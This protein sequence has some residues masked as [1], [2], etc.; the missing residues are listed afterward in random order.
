MLRPDLVLA[1]LFALMHPDQAKGHA[2][3]FYQPVPKA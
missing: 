3:T 1:D 2:F